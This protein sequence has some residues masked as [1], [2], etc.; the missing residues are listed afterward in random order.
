MGA[1][2]R[3]HVYYSNG[4]LET[5]P[6]ERCEEQETAEYLGNQDQRE[7]CVGVDRQARFMSGCGHIAHQGDGQQS[8][9]YED[10]DQAHDEHTAIFSDHVTQ[11]DYR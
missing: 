2:S 3:A 6:R 9:A 11:G 1:I 4:L 8:C 5:Q 7:R 10:Q